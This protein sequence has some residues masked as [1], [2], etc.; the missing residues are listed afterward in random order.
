[1]FLATHGVIWDNSGSSYTARTTAFATATSI[2]DTTI[3]NAL[4]TFDLGLISNGLDTKMKAI[5]PMVGGTSTTCKYNFMDARD[6]D[7]AFRLQFFGGGTFS[8]NGYTGNGTNAY[9]ETF[10]NPVTQSLSINSA[11]L[12]YYARTGDNNNNVW[13]GQNSLAGF[14]EN[15]YGGTIYA[16]LASSY[17]TI[18]TGISNLFTMVNRNSSNYQ[19]VRRQGSSLIS[20]SATST[21]FNS[22]N[23]YINAYNPSAYFS[24]SNCAFASIGDGM[25]DTEATT[26]YNLVQAM[27][28]SLSRA[29]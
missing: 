14:L 21:G 27:Q 17:M 22:G 23:F 2:T 7:V 16:G 6:L 5:Y 24:S 20:S 3:L 9:G 13:I 11:H 25:T 15:I 4:N 18:S 10:F 8:S 26:F 19:E 28:V 29:V 12:S 1:M